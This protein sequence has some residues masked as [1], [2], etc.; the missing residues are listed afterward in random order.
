MHELA[1][2][3]LQLRRLHNINPPPPAPAPSS[4]YA[5][6]HPVEEGGR[7]APALERNLQ[8]PSNGRLGAGGGDGGQS[9]RVLGWSTARGW[10]SRLI[11]SEC[12]GALGFIADYRHARLLFLLLLFDHRQGE[13]KGFHFARKRKRFSLVYS[14]SST[15]RPPSPAVE[16]NTE[17]SI[18][19]CRGRDR[20][21]RLSCW[22]F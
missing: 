1:E 21:C 13:R 3:T 12:G 8:M 22:P 10:K 18:S 14:R 17:I 19:P 5:K 4:S 7:A 9:G 20:T 16:R 2:V 6:G 15:G 11:F